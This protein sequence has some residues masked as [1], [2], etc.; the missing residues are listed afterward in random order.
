MKFLH[1][2]DW[3][4]GAGEGIKN[5]LE[6]QKYFIDQICDIIKEHKVDAVLLAGD[7]YD[8]SVAS[9]DAIRMYDY[10][11]TRICLELKTPVLSVAGNHDSGERLSSCSE[12]LA[13]SGLYIA[14]SLSEKIQKVSFEDAEVYLLPWITEEK[15][16]SIYPAEKETVH[17][18]ED[19]YRVVVSK[20]RDDF[21]KE[22]K[23]IIVAHAFITNAETSESDRSAVIGYATQVP[24]SV[25]DGFDYAALGHIHKPQ[26]VTKTVRYCG[27]PMPYSFGREETQDKS[28]TIVNTV[29]MNREVIPL[30]L[31]HLRATIEGTK[32]ELL[33]PV[34]SEEV[35]KGYVR[36]RVTDEYLG[37]ELSSSLSVLYP[38]FLELYGKTFEGTETKVTLTME[39]FEKSEKDPIE[40]FKYYCMEETEEKEP[41]E[42]ILGLFEKAVKKV[43]EETE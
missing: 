40:I 6:D 19:A 20:I 23:H 37:P 9:A 22:K 21:D 43:E 16:K 27:T 5:F 35:R 30:S 17:S 31:L 8:R 34:C 7:I 2:S 11:M 12:L 41:N 3:H 28:V 36:L 15:V 33:N 32:E 26:D 29:D 25:F 10:A 38:N 18:F 1:T 14:G 4:L 24:A 39:Q 42:H 13:A